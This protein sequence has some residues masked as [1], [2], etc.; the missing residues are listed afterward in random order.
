MNYR[1]IIIFYLLAFCY[2]S[3]FYLF[4]FYFRSFF[5]TSTFSGKHVH[6]VRILFLRA[7][8]DERVELWSQAAQ[9]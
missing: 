2:Y 3:L 4:I 9:T 1:K 6:T 8:L 5:S 7:K